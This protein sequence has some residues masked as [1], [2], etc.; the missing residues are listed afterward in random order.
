MSS[1]TVAVK[2]LAITSEVGAKY[3]AILEF[4]VLGIDTSA[5]DVGVGSRAR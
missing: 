3:G 5:D 4:G 1:V 2:V